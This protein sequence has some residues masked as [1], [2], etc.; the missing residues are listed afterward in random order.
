MVDLVLVINIIFWMG[1]AWLTYYSEE[2]TEYFYV[3][4]YFFVLGAL[5]VAALFS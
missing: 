4:R 1:I 3:W 5:N 2:D